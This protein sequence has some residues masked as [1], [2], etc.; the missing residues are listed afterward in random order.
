MT[1]ARTD[2]RRGAGSSPLLA[3][4]TRHELTDLRGTVRLV[5]RMA[6]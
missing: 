1:E 6:P 4:V 5:F 3:G 2:S